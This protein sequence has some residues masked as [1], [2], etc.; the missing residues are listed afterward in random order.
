MFFFVLSYILFFFMCRINQIEVHTRLLLVYIVRG[1]TLKLR[2][3]NM[4]Q[5]IIPMEMSIFFLWQPDETIEYYLSCVVFFFFF[6]VG[7]SST[8]RWLPIY[9][10]YSYCGCVCVC[11][12]FCRLIERTHTYKQRD[13]R[14]R[15]MHAELIRCVLLLQ[16]YCTEINFAQQLSRNCEIFTWNFILCT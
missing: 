8:G 2:R 12:V 10:F 3:R 16:V 13:K 7:R 1:N 14:V 5:N 11:V 6:F 4:Q 15:S 9:K